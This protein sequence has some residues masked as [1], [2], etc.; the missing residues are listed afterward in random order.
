MHRIKHSRTKKT[1][2]NILIPKV[3]RFGNKG[4]ICHYNLV[5]S[6][7]TSEMKRFLNAIWVG[8]VFEF[9]F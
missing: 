9:S 4:L 5:L 2:G 7:Q 8:L 1:S 6:F 3:K